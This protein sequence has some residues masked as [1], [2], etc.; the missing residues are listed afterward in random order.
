M[1]SPTL[2][3]WLLL[4][5]IVA[6]VALGIRRNFGRDRVPTSADRPAEFR[7]LASTV[8]PPGAVRFR[9]PMNG[10]VEEVG[11]AGFWCLIF[12]FFYLAYKGAW[13]AAAIGFGLAIITGGLSWF[14]LPFFARGM[15]SKGYL[16]RGWIPV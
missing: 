15:V 5:V 16:Q 6:V 1:D 12:G 14:I 8:I 2:G 7:G 13:T 9:N 4:I 10:Y 11:H 3:H